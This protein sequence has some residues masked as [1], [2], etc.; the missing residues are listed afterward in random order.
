MIYHEEMFGADTVSGA[1]K[2]G[3]LEAVSD[4]TKYSILA[5]GAVA[6]A[7]LFLTDSAR[8]R[9]VKKVLP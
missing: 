4:A 7:Y 2:E 8:K 5:A 3:A 1:I 6:L 9:A